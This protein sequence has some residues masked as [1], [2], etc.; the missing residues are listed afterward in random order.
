[1]RILLDTQIFIWCDQQPRMVEPRSLAALQDIGND[2]FV[3]VA[4]IWEIAIKRAI[5]KLQFAAPIAE[6]VEKLGFGLLPIASAHAEHAG[7]LPRHHND[8][9][10][11]LIIAQAVLEGLLLATRDRAMQL[12]EVPTLGLE[13][14]RI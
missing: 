14:R 11:R 2:V 3:S 8:P 6:T 7:E 1:M 5:G 10:D 12:Y 13:R 4:S 9:F